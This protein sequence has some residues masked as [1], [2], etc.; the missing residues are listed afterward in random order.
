MGAN[1]SGYDEQLARDMSASSSEDKEQPSEES[2]E[3]PPLPGQPGSD[4]EVDLANT[5]FGLPPI[6]NDD[7][8]V[9]TLIKNSFPIL[10]IRP[11]KVIR[12]DTAQG[13][14]QTEYLGDT[15][16]FICQNDGSTSYNLNNEYEAS[17]MEDFFK[18]TFQIN[19]ISQLHQIMN[20]SKLGNK[21]FEG[22]KGVMNGTKISDVF[23][24]IGNLGN[25]AIDWSLQGIH[26]AID[27]IDNDESKQGAK[28]MLQTFESMGRTLIGAAFKGQKIDIPNIWTGSSGKV[29]QRVT[30]KLHCLYPGIDSAFYNDIALPLRILY[31]LAAPYSKTESDADKDSEDNENDIITYENPPYVEAELDGLFTTRIGA[32][33]SLSVNFDFKNMSFAKNRPYLATVDLEIIDLYDVIVWHDK[34]NEQGVYAPNGN[35]I[36]YD[37]YNRAKDPVQPPLH[38]DLAFQFLPKGDPNFGFDGWLNRMTNKILN[39]INKVLGAVSNVASSVM[40]VAANFVD[41]AIGLGMDALEVGADALFGKNSLIGQG[42]TSI[43]NGLNNIATNIDSSGNKFVNNAFSSGDMVKIKDKA[44]ALSTAE[45]IR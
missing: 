5:L 24:A 40:G 33:S 1:N 21:F 23:G 38:A 16:K 20:T 45:A 30:I 43:S 17:I 41:Q 25:N 8:V 22:T 37:L 31:R 7:P 32:I 35:Q 9:S 13:I 28:K 18:E 27:S 10:K 26:N 12:P 14:T 34:V 44:K 3:P 39:P 36:V 4:D 19:A 2:K 15:Y 11:M 42:A 6:Y 29:S